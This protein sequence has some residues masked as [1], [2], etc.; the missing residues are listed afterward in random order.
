MKNL[1]QPI[2][3]FIFLILTTGIFNVYAAE[4]KLSAYG[5][6]SELPIEEYT[7]ELL[8][9]G[10]VLFKKKS[11]DE[12]EGEPVIKLRG[13][14]IRCCKAIRVRQTVLNICKNITAPRCP[15]GTRRK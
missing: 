15:R 11:A 14:I 8:D 13:G 9:D 2:N 6:E 7:P 4:S 1:Q 3:F 12:G 5:T 10:S